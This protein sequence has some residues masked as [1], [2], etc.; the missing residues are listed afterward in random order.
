MSGEMPAEM[1]RQFKYNIPKFEEYA[2]AAASKFSKI[3]G[4]RSKGNLPE[5]IIEPGTALAANV[6]NFICSVV[7]IKKV[8]DKQI[9]TSSGSIYNIN[10][11][12]NR[13]NV[14]LQLYLKRGTRCD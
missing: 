9:V 10:P 2:Q 3:I 8:R 12:P 4:E 13:I 14:P 7:S 11:T 6:V 1:E 5:L